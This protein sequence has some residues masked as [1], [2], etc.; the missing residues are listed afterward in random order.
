MRR[1]LA[2]LAGRLGTTP[3][4]PALK[5]RVEAEFDPATFGGTQAA[6]EHLVEG[7]HLHNARWAAALST[8][9]ARVER[10]RSASWGTRRD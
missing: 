6:R 8:A 1:L 4:D 5:A 7:T 10:A 2:R 9:S 3:L